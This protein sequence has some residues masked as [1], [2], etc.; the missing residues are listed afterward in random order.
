MSPET[1]KKLAQ[2]KKYSASLK[3]LFQ[4]AAAFA[5]IAGLV[6]LLLV[7]TA[8]VGGEDT[9]RTI[10]FVGLSY[11]G[12]AITWPVKIVIAIGIALIFAIIISLLH[13]LAK[14]FAH[15]SQGEIF[16]A[17]SVRRIRDIGIAVFMFIAV[18]IYALVGAYILQLLERGTTLQ[19][20]RT[21]GIGI[22]GPFAI[23]LTGIIIIIVSWVMDVGRELR[24]EHDLTV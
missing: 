24:E 7:L 11:S 13:N 5:G 20:T 10:D 21:I 17:G 16:T 14:L 19:Q 6:S 4:L 12:D 3:T 18:W 9:G 2:V 22:P 1:E 23:V 8:P 15:Y